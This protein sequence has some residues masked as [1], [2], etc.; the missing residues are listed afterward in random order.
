MIVTIP[1]VTHAP[2]MLLTD[3][4]GTLANEHSAFIFDSAD[5]SRT[6][7]GPITVLPDIVI[8][9]YSSTPLNSSG[10]DA[11]IQFRVLRMR[12]T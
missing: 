7:H 12:E 5:G 4:V 8:A 10:S 11:K 3:G 1:R 2:G 6:Q 9:D